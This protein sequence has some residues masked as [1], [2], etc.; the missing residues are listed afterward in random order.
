VA[1]VMVTVVDPARTRRTNATHSERERVEQGWSG[2][3][4]GL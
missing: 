4:G 1:V 2:R 3:A